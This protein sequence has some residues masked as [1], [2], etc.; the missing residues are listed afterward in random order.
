MRYL[1]HSPGGAV[2]RLEID[3]GGAVSYS[4][5]GCWICHQMPFQTAQTL[6]AKQGRTLQFVPDGHP[7]PDLLVTEYPTPGR[8]IE[9]M[10]G[11]P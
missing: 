9:D 11:K 10:R 4:T 5:P 1:V 2:D 7:W 6:L 3:D 8:S